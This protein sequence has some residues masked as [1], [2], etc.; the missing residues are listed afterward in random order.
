MQQLEEARK[1]DHRKL[2]QE[3]NLFVLDPMVGSGLVLWKPKG[4]VVRFELEKLMRSE[5][6]KAGYKTVYTPHIGKLHLY[7]TSGHFPYYKESQF[8]P[9]YESRR[10]ELLNEL[11]EAER[12]RGDEGQL[13]PRIEAA[14]AQLQAEQPDLH[15][16]H[17]W[18][19][20]FPWG[21]DGIPETIRVFVL[22][23]VDLAVSKLSRFSA[24]ASKAMLASVSSISPS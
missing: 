17:I 20:R 15:V 23:P 7:R 2:G 18:G 13:S 12:Q 16:P 24:I 22:K 11:W 14:L 8:P 4:S 19:K 21:L 9:L 10:A 5:L 6:V 3:L 1:R